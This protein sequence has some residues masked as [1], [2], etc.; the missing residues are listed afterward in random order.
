MPSYVDALRRG[1]SYDSHRT[2]ETIREDLESIAR[3]AAGFVAGQTDREGKGPPVILPDGSR[4]PRLPGYR[5][6]MWDGDFCG[7]IQLRWRPGSHALPPYCLGHIGYGVVPW[8]RGRGLAKRALGLLRERVRRE[9]LRYADIV[10]DLDNAV[11]QKVIVAN[12]GVAFERFRTPAEC[13]GDDCLRFRWYTGAPHPLERETA[14]LRLRQ[15]RDEDRAPFAALNADPL[16]MEH[17]PAPLAR[18]ASDALVERSRA[19]IASRGWGLWAVERISDRRFLGFVGLTVVPE[20]LPFAPA[21]EVGWRVAREAWGAGYAT[22]AAREALR[23]AFET[24]DLPEVVSFT[25]AT[26]ERS[27]AVMRRLG[28]REDGRFD[29]PRLAEGHRLRRHRLF[30]LARA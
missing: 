8:K 25:A 9:G 18:E 5:L 6:W 3:D 24:V 30:R 26:N 19:A 27:M 7:A 15:W 22:E 20:Y 1:W 2:E 16:V 21:L 12:G 14:R 29:H 23:V 11:S 28:M 17:F 4:V 10:A 13:G